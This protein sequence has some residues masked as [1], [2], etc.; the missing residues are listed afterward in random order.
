MGFVARTK[1]PI[2]ETGIC[3]ILPVFRYLK[4]AP[5]RFFVPGAS[6]IPSRTSVF[7]G[8]FARSNFDP[9]LADETGS[10]NDSAWK[11]GGTFQSGIF[12]AG[13]V[14]RF[15]GKAFSPIGFQYFTSDRRAIETNAGVTTGTLS[16][17]G[18]FATARDNVKNDPDLDTTE[19]SNGNLNLVWTASPKVTLSLGYQANGQSTT[20]DLGDP[21]FPQ[22]SRTKQFSGGLTL[23]PS[24]A[25]NI[26]FQV[27]DSDVSSRTSP[28]ANS[29][30]VNLSLGG[31]LRA[32]EILS[33]APSV[34]YT[35]AKNK[36]T[37]EKQITLNTFFAADLTILRQ[38]LSTSFQGGYTRADNGSMGVSEQTCLSGLINFHLKKLI[39]FGTVILS[40]RAN[41]ARTKMPGYANTIK[42]ALAQCDFAF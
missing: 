24:P 9:N 30:G 19:I 41:Y 27:A 35:N 12:Q 22:D 11:V 10:K 8:E 5:V 23:M 17:M 15:I 7:G 13:A 21:F 3:R 31:S 4:F 33:I 14:Y 18:A 28:Q 39:K 29:R 26:S 34:G 20:R 36:F 42:S 40:L 32:G 16:L 37:G 38:W 25:A 2:Q 1:A 6:V